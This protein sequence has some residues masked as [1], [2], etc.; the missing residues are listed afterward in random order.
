[1]ASFFFR[2]RFFELDR[3]SEHCLCL[4]GTPRIVQLAKA[5][6]TAARAGARD[7]PN[8]RLDIGGVV[9][10]STLLSGMRRIAY[11][12]ANDFRFAD[13]RNARG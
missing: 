4:S 13:L 6:A 7:L 3:G 9:S 1:M 8:V 2:P 11:A 12:D 10:V 5:A